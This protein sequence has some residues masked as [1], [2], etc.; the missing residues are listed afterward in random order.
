MSTL[1]SFL[2]KRLRVLI[3]VVC[4]LSLFNTSAQQIDTSFAHQGFSTYTPS[5]FHHSVKILGRSDGKMV[6]LGQVGSSDSIGTQRDYCVF[7]I[8]TTGTL[9]STFGINGYRIGDFATIDFSR[10]VDFEI[11]AH[12]NLYI[13]GSGYL[14]KG[15]SRTPTVIMK[16]GSNGSLDSSFA[17]NGQKVLY[18][19]GYQDYPNDIELGDSGSIWVAGG[20]NDSLGLYSR[21]YL[22]N[23]SADGNLDSTWNSTGVY[24]YG[25]LRKPSY[26]DSRNGR[27]S[28]STE[29]YGIAIQNDTIYTCGST[30][31]NNGILTRFVIPE[32][33]DTT[34]ADSGHAIF[35]HPNGD[36]LYFSSIKMYRNQ[37]L[38]SVRLYST[39]V[40]D[41]EYVQFD[42][43]LNQFV[44]NR[45]SDVN[46][47]VLS[48]IEIRHSKV[49]MIGHSTFQSNFSSDYFSDQFQ[50]SV[51]DSTFSPFLDF[52]DE[53]SFFYE[54][55]PSAQSGALHGI[56]YDDTTM[57]F[58]GDQV[59][60]ID[61]LHFIVSKITLP[62][63]ILDFPQDTIKDTIVDTT[64]LT[65]RILMDPKIYPNPTKDY[66]NIKSGS[67]IHCVT[68][69]NLLGEDVAKYYSNRF[70]LASL[71]KGMYQLR[72]N[73]SLGIVN[74]HLIKN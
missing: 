37:P 56:F 68:I 20:A 34:F 17:D 1:D 61:E 49:F 29:Y 30:P 51:H 26:Q 19:E 66:V 2:F 45:V 11:D 33:L 4:V 16:L 15:S 5:D 32:G 14:R 53:G 70:S 42:L 69:V 72:I 74:K 18:V 71:P 64:G 39:G 50:V 59:D 7:V 47:N 67:K 43:E 55:E 12:D 6:I 38:M 27:H 25:K 44:H 21:A 58:V 41:F 57:F 22:I 40:Q 10:P 54:H 52:G 3:S 36:N 65:S 63:S 73:T 31:S 60:T 23:L 46:H 35:E 9:D 24:S 62:E 28:A 8:D 48:N 13:L